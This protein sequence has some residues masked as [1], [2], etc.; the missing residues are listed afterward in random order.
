M[1]DTKIS[2]LTAIGALADG[3]EFAVA[4]VSGA[5]DSR[6][7][8][9]SQ[10]KTYLQLPSAIYNAS[11]AAQGAGFATDTYLIGSSIAIPAGRLQAKSM[12]RCFF[13]VS[14][15]AGTGTGVINIR[16][17]TTGTTSDASRATI[18]FPSAGTAV[19]D[20]GFIEIFVTFRSVGS[21]TSAIIQVFCRF[22]RINTT[23]GFIGTGGTNRHF[24]DVTS[25]GFDS[26]VANSIIG[27]SVNGG[28]SAAWTVALTQAELFNL[29]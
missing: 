8:T 15:T 18:T 11:V 21:G 2:G 14:K 20:N 6:S 3:D 24:F 27:V 22:H 7:V 12:Y 9:A 23:T 17:G 19:A 13:R 10:I 1:A 26:T 29:A 28:T 25:S 4:D 5:P 16:I